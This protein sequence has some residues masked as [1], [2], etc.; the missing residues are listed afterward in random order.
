[1]AVNAN[2]VTTINLEQYVNVPAL[3]PPPGVIPNFAIPNERAEVYKTLCS[4][5]LAIL[6]VFLCLRLYAK[7]WIKRNPGFDDRK[8]LTIHRLATSS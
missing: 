6:Y 2:D 5:L 4:A 1:M 3:E 7:I 8:T